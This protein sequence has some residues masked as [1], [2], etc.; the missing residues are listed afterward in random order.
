MTNQFNTPL[1][2]INSLSE[3]TGCD[4]YGKAEY[5]NQ[6]GSVKDRP[7]LYMINY[8]EREGLISPDGYIVEATAGNTGFGLLHFANQRGY[9]CLFCCPESVSS[10]KIDSLKS[11]GAE[12]FMCPCVSIDHPDHYQNAAR[13]KAIELNGYFTNQFYNPINHVAHYETTGPEI[14]E[15]TNGKVN[16]VIS[17]SG[18]GGTIAG[19]S[20]YLKEKNSNI[21]CYLIVIQ[22]QKTKLDIQDKKL[23]EK[24]S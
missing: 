11:L 20:L 22:G 14:W 23:K 10:E 17:A 16:A 24:K 6:G 12:I 5:L 2:R 15:Q 13:K 21:K 19:C 1:I 7:A 9:K 4:I 8:A 3:A 18:T